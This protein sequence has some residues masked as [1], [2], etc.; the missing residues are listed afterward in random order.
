MLIFSIED[1]WKN[2]GLLSVFFILGLL[3]VESIWH[4]LFVFIAIVLSR[5]L[6]KELDSNA[7]YFN[8]DELAEYNSN[9]YFAYYRMVLSGSYVFV[10]FSQDSMVTIDISFFLL[11]YIG[12][13]FY[14]YT[15]FFIPSNGELSSSSKVHASLGGLACGTSVLG[16]LAWIVSHGNGY[17][18]L[19]PMIT[20]PIK[21]LLGIG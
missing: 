14:W 21:L 20:N 13:T 10:A 17:D 5:I 6:A 3:F 7:I 8:E 4:G 2:I 12:Y 16:M 19:S 18:W 11:W 1:K 15:T 9:Y